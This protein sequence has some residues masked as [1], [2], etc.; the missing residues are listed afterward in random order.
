MDILR[1]EIFLEICQFYRIMC[2]ICNIGNKFLGVDMHLLLRNFMIS[3]FFILI[4]F[5]PQLSL[6]QR[7]EVLIPNFN[8]RAVVKIFCYRKVWL[9]D[10]GEKLD[11]VFW[12]RPYLSHGSGVLI[13]SDGIIIT[14]KHVVKDARFVAVRIPGNTITYPAEQ[15]PSADNSDYAFLV[16]RGNFRDYVPLP[17]RPPIMRRGQTIW[18]YGYPIIPGEL[19]PNITKGI[20]TRFSTYFN[21]WQLDATVH[22]GS[23]GG[24][25]V[26]NNGRICGIIVAQLAAGLNFAIP[27]DTIITNYR[28]LLQSGLMDISKNRIGGISSEHYLAKTNLA[29]CFSNLIMQ[30]LDIVSQQ[31]FEALKSDFSSISYD[32]SKFLKEWAIF[33][34]LSACYYFNR[35]TDILKQNNRSWKQVSELKSE[36]KSEY[37]RWISISKNEVDIAK[38]CDKDASESVAE[39]EL[40][41]ILA[42]VGGGVGGTDE[43]REP[44][45]W[46]DNEVNQLKSYLGKHKTDFTDYWGYVEEEVASNGVHMLVYSN[47]IVTLDDR[48]YVFSIGLTPEKMEDEFFPSLG[49][50]KPS[51]TRYQLINILGN[52][53]KESYT[54]NREMLT[55]QLG[56]NLEISVMLNSDNY[57]YLIMIRKR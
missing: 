11:P 51:Y 5:L 46:S 9:D 47:V 42:L 18:T 8:E 16:I 14:A 56:S 45:K 10:R 54:S 33:K 32:S 49:G 25:L 7:G 22:P 12:A 50:I 39:L 52:N 17:Q 30:D 34:E 3:S 19:E 35:A 13:S 48:G 31:E 23:S 43:T 41:V 2:Y 37:L 4:F 20:I 44:K 6:A 29:K 38:N 55:W 53:Y 21:M 27:I 26:D 36:Q 57:I 28:N 24:P 15:I 1:M 40:G